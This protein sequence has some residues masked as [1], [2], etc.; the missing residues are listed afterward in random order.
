M[1]SILIVEDHKIVAEV[2]ANILRHNGQYEVAG[3]VHTAEA[4]MERLSEQY[5]DLVLVDVS[6]PYTTGIELVS[7]ICREYP[8]HPMPYDL[9]P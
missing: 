7:M 1:P 4:A 9:G 8:P 3:V 5:I 6:L 2:L